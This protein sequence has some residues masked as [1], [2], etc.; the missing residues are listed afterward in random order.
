MTQAKAVH[1]VDRPLAA[2]PR[3]RLQWRNG[4]WHVFDTRDW[5]VYEARSMQVDAQAILDDL[6]LMEALRAS[7]KPSKREVRHAQRH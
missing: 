7:I 4:T 5:R 1:T 2:A 3:Y 6:R